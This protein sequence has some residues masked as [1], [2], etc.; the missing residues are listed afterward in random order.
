[1]IGPQHLLIPAGWEDISTNKYLNITPDQA[2]I[3][4]LAELFRLI[5]LWEA[6]AV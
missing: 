4:R 2:L 6:K 5:S 1:M 3:L